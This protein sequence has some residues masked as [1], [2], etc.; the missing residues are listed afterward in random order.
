MCY[1]LNVLQVPK[2]R[3]T[4]ERDSE[5][6]FHHKWNFPHSLGALDGRHMRIQCPLNGGSLYYNYCG[7]HSIVLFALV[8][9]TYKFLYYEVGAQG[10]VGDATILNASNLKRDLKNG[11]LNT[12]PALATPQMN[13]PTPSLIVADSAFAL[14]PKLMK[15]YPQRGTEHEK[16]IFNY[17]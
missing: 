9:A 11:R 3:R 8:D 15:P 16:K 13:F 6:K 4:V 7:F 2:H 17:S 5:H 10:R 14:S 1:F 12:P